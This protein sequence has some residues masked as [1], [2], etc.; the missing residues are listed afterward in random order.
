MKRVIAIRGRQRAAGGH[1]QLKPAVRTKLAPAG[2]SGQ[3]RKHHGTDSGTRRS[4]TKRR[5]REVTPPQNFHTA[6]ARSGTSAEGRTGASASPPR[7]RRTVV[8]NV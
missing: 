6:W 8:S 7:P 3:P 2:A 1:D 4:Q 5:R